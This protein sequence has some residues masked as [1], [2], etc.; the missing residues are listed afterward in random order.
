MTKQNGTPS[1]FELQVLG[2]LWRE[3]SLTVRQLLERLP[4]GKTRAYTSVLSVMQVMEKKGLLTRQPAE[5][6]LAHVYKAKV[7]QNKVMGSMLRSMVTKIFGGN[8]LAAVQQ[9]LT[10]TNVN[11]DEIAQIR[12]LLSDLENQKK[13]KQS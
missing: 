9:L 11:A 2:V 5:K 10:E 12:E 6:G 8:S 4:D 7:A 13:G 3:G 1:E